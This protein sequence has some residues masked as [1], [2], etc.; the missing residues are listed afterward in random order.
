MRHHN[1]LIQLQ[2][3]RDTADEHVDVRLYK[4]KNEQFKYEPLYDAV[5]TP[6]KLVNGANVIDTYRAFLDNEQY[7]YDFVDESYISSFG[8]RNHYIHD[9]MIYGYNDEQQ[10]FHVYSYHGPKL[11]E[12]DIPYEE[13]ALAYDSGHQENQY[14][15]TSLYKKKEDEYRIDIDKI[16]NYLLDYLEG[17]NTYNRENLHEVALYKPQF[18]INIYN[19]IK[20][21]IA[22]ERERRTHIDMPG[23]YCI[24]DH[25]R[26]MKERVVYLDQHTDLKCPIKLQ[27]QFQTVERAGQL[28][29]MLALKLDQTGFRNKTDFENMMKRIDILKEMEEK[30]LSEYYEYNRNVFESV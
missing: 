28:F 18:G 3:S 20:Y 12:Y 27:K 2:T 25:K 23:M 8:Y 30:T 29:A 4:K 22:Y 16:G 26:L 5:I 15:Y 21:M 13:Y 6:K 11:T 19:E 14:H 9:L 24:Y 10:V 1:E 17:I 7:I